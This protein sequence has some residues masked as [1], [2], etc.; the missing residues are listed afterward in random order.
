MIVFIDTS[1]IK[2]ETT[3]NTA[4]SLIYTLESSHALGFSVF[5]RLILATDFK[6]V[7][8]LRMKSSLHSP[9]HFLPF[10]LSYLGRPYSQLDPFLDKNSLKINFSS[11]LSQLLTTNSSQTNPSL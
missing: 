6:I 1:Y 8:L 2:L 11:K 3:N 5:T 9:I 10:L 7:S 4:L